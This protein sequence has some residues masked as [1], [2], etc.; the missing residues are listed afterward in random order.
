MKPKAFVSGVTGQDGSYLAEFLLEKGYQVYGL[1]RRN[2]DN[3][4]RRIV[5]LINRIELVSG[6]LTDQGSLE[7]LLMAIQ[8]DEIYNLGAQSFVKLSFDAPD[9]TDDVTGD[10]A[11]RLID[12]ARNVCRTAKI[13][14]A[15]SSEQFGNSTQSPQ[16]EQTPFRPASPYGCSKVYAHLFAEMYRQT[17]GMFI[18]C[19]IWFNHESPRR[20]EEFVTRK[21]TRAVA[22]I[23]CGLQD[24]LVLGNLDSARDWSHAKDAVRSMW[25]SLQYASPETYVFGSG[26]AYSIR[27]FLDR[28]FGC[29]G[30]SAW[31]PYVSTDPRFVRPQDVKHLV[32]NRSK[33][34]QILGWK[35]EISF[36]ELVEEMVE[37]DLKETA[38][39]LDRDPKPHEG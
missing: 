26:K 9:H 24:S 15:S 22:R 6:D 10:G 19:G 2:S 27:E 25:M 1:M 23:K 31:Q 18:V 32:A 37:H 35:P 4:M 28:A 21:I 13:Y 17:Y 33:A 12:S 11:A 20:G 30:I 7:R 39:T 8:P 5:H 38:R 16:N 3:S 14:Q 36:Q 29:V 34:T